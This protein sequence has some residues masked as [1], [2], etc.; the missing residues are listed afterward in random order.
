LLP[1][2]LKNYYRYQ[3]SWTLPPCI[4]NSENFVLA[5]HQTISE[6]QLN[7]FRSL[8]DQDGSKMGDNYRAISEANMWNKDNRRNIVASY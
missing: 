7:A 1:K 4:E 5:G 6:K 8:I 3:G 2:D